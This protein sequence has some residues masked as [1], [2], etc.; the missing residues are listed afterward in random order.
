MGV[1]LVANISPGQDVAQIVPLI[2]LLVEV[3]DDTNFVGGLAV[4]NTAFQ[5]LPRPWIEKRQGPQELPPA[6]AWPAFDSNALV[7]LHLGFPGIVIQV[8]QLLLEEVSVP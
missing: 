4:P 5:V 7:V 6:T 1:F 8:T 2:L 3:V